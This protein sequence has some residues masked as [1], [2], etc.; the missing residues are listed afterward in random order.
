MVLGG[1]QRGQA[2]RS[3][4]AGSKGKGSSADEQA[5]QRGT[6]EASR[7]DRSGGAS[8]VG[9]KREYLLCE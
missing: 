3:S 1:E 6:D 9:N 7:T 5:K 4:E 8:C 2:R